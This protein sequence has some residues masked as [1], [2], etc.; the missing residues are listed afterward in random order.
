LP[1]DAR[2]LQRARRLLKSA[3]DA[4]AVRQG[5]EE[6][7]ANREIEQALTKLIREGRGRFVD[8]YEDRS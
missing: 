3:S 6:T 5:I 4:E 8:V 7:I 1:V 2:L